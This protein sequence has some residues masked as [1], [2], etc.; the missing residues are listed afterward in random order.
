METVCSSETS[1]IFH[2]TTW[3]YIPEDKTPQENYL[4][5]NYDWQK[6]LSWS[7]Y[8]TPLMEPENSLSCSQKP[9][10]GLYLRKAIPVNILT[11][12]FFKIIFNIIVLRTV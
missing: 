12:Y 2:R 1:V 5:K 3:R 9:A 10:T 11:F 6:L 4:C 8:L 7:R